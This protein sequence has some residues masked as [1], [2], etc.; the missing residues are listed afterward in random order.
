MENTRRS[1]APNEDSISMY[2]SFDADDTL[3]SKWQSVM[4]SQTSQYL[5]V[6]SLETDPKL[7]ETLEDKANKQKPTVLQALI[8]NEN[9]RDQASPLRPFDQS[10]LNKHNALCST[11]TKKLTKAGA[12]PNAT[13]P[14][15]LNKEN[16]PPDAENS[17][18]SSSIDATASTVKTNTMFHADNATQEEIS[19]QESC[20]R[21]NVYP[22]NADVL[23]EN[24]TEVSNE[25][26]SVVLPSASPLVVAPMLEE[27]KNPD[28]VVTEM[29]DEV[30]QLIAKALQLTEEPRKPREEPKPAQK[31]PLA[32]L[33]RPRRSYLPMASGGAMFKQRM[34]IVVKTTLNSPAR[35]LITSSNTRRSCLPAPRASLTGG[36]AGPRKSTLLRPSESS[37]GS[38]SRGTALLSGS[39]VA[40]KASAKPRASTAFDAK[41]NCKLCSARFRTEHQ[42]DLHMRTH[43]EADMMSHKRNLKVSNTCKFCD[44]KFA[45]ERALHIHLLQNCDKIPPSEKR[46]LQYTELNHVKKAQLPKLAPGTGAVS[47]T[48]PK[49]RQSTM[50]AL[51]KPP[52]A[53]KNVQ[54]APP[55]LLKVPKKTAHA[56]VYRTPTKS[57]PCHICGLSFKSILAYTN[58]CLS[59][60]SKHQEPQSD[61]APSA[62]D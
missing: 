3:A 35:K 17:T 61:S 5:E 2:L 33:P 8:K 28:I 22:L 21:T 34:S 62:Q 14:D 39:T 36:S 32:N 20:N 48:T 58:H 4:A 51:D 41:I 26:P 1:I 60:H 55:S 44:K 38:S 52:P 15:N 50:P 25:E 16:S 7:D 12:C 46:K 9:L 31:V 49:P 59:V 54:M 47:C 30:S 40:G 11:P 56:G 27:I 23:L 29:V 24:I 19:V 18:L 42:L 43:L 53:T 6:A 10:I 13:T 37:S 45:L 57:V